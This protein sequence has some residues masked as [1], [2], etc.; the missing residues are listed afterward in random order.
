MDLSQR[1]YISDNKTLAISINNGV[2]FSIAKG[3]RV[4][5]IASGVV[6]MLGEIPFYGKIIIITHESGFRSV[7]S[8]LS[9]TNVKIG[10]NIKLNQVIGKTGE[11]LEGQTMHFE[12]LARNATPLNPREWLRF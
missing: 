3:S 5:A 10:D 9:E 7:Y 11:T 1:T 2:D 6:T 12:L 8:S 4:Y